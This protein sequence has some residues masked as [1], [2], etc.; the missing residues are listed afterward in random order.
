M[1]LR[2][3]TEDDFYDFKE[4]YSNSNFHWL[5]ASENLNPTPEQIKEAEEMLFQM[6]FE[7]I[8]DGYKNYSKD[9]YINDYIM[10]K[11]KKLFLIENSS[12]V[13][14]IITYEHNGRIKILEW[15]MKFIKFDVLQ[16][17]LNLLKLKFRGKTLQVNVTNDYAKDLLYKLGF[18]GNDDFIWEIT[19]L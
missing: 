11:N 10:S 12:I 14:Y 7:K 3:A 19:F 1:L 5:H 9:K 17:I 18:L 2:N 6:G 16:S 13:G 15:A 4:L 8:E